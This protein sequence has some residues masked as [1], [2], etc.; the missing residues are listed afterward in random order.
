[1]VPD[2][3]RNGDDLFFPVFSSKEEMGEYGEDFSKVQ[4][5]FLDALEMAIE[6]EKNVKG[7]V[8]N[9]FSGSFVLEREIFDIVQ[10]MKSRIE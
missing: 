1:M 4:M 9:A 10:N 7:I 6:N 8:L 2:I 5:H 3:L